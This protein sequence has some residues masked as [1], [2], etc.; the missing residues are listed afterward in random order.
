MTT[1]ACNTSLAP[2]GPFIGDIIL[3]IYLFIFLCRP[4]INYLFPCISNIFFNFLEMVQ[5]TVIPVPVLGIEYIAGPVVS[6]LS[7]KQ[8][9]MFVA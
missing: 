8:S 4:V 3:F 2:S 6:I 9:S 1:N 5:D 7:S